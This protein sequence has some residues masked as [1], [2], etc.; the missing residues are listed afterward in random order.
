MSCDHI[1][2]HVSVSLGSVGLSDCFMRVGWVGEW[3]GGW[4]ALIVWNFCF[5]IGTIIYKAPPYVAVW[6]VCVYMY[7]YTHV[8]NMYVCNIYIYIYIY[9]VLGSTT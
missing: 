6:N 4:L 1:Y 3:V 7:I 2:T 9:L 5:I 8:P